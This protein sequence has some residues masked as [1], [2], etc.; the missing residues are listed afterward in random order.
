M[1]EWLASYIGAPSA[2]AIGGAAVIAFAVFGAARDRQVR[3][4]DIPSLQSTIK[5]A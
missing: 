5:G 1:R 3:R 4:L 2:V